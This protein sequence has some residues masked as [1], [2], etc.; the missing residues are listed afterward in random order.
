MNACCGRVWYW[1][2]AQLKREKGENGQDWV[3]LEGDGH[4]RDLVVVICEVPPLLNVCVRFLVCRSMNSLNEHC[5][6]KVVW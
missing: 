1:V 4:G 5:R 3:E 6:D 2:R